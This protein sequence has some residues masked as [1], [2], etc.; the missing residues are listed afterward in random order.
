MA[1][2]HQL[3]TLSIL[4]LRKRKLFLLKK[5]RFSPQLIRAS[6]V[7]R[8][9]KCGKPNCRCLQGH[10]HGPFYYL[11]QCL[12]VGRMRKFLLKTPESQQ[13][14]REAVRAFNEYYDQLELLSQIN[15]ELLARGENLG[16]PPS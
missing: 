16:V 9:T 4:A 6:V 13:Q 1:K 7:E 3:Q 5:L 15:T 12:G 2:D 14:A 8:F 11:T 10:L